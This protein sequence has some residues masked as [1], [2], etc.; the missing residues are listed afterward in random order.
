LPGD[1][2]LASFVDRRG[3]ELAP[4]MNRE[5]RVGEVFNG[6]SCKIMLGRLVKNGGAGDTSGYD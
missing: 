3:V 5:V 6:L 4:E 2:Y 1:T